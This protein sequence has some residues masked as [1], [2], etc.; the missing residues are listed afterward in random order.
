MKEAFCTKS[1]QTT[2]FNNRRRKPPKPCL[3]C[4][5]LFYAEKTNRIYCSPKCAGR[6][7]HMPHKPCLHCQTAFRPHSPLTQYCSRECATSNGD[8]RQY[9]WRRTVRVQYPALFFQMRPLIAERDLNCVACQK[10][11]ADCHH[12]D[13]NMTNNDPTNLVMLCREHH[14]A[15]HSKTGLP[16]LS[17][18]A[19]GKN[20]SMTSKWK[21]RSASLQTSFSSTTA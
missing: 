10:P 17:A 16:W 3:L 2:T 13:E 11:A 14:R 18:Y 19:I 21:E 15:A 4:Q 7:A 5:T 8:T 20:M 9:S 1:C 6:A 12:I